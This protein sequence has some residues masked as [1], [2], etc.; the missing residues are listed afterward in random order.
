MATPAVRARHRILLVGTARSGTS[1]LG[2]AMGRAPGARFYYEPDN[3]DADPTEANSA[4]RRGFGPYPLI[5]PGED[6]NTFTPLWDMVFSGRFPFSAG[7]KQRLRPAARAVLQMPRAIRDPIVRRAATLSTRLPSRPGWTIVKSIYATFSL[8]WLTQRYQ[9]Q[10]VAIQRHPFNV[11]SSWRQLKIP[12]FDLAGRP[13]MRERFLHPLGI[14]P[15]AADASELT[16]IAWHVGLLTHVLGDAVD[17]HPD[18]H[19]ATHEDL[20]AD[21]SR[22]IHDIFDRVG[23]TWTSG[24]ERFL[25]E[26]DQPGEGLKPVRVTAEQPDR[27][28]QRLSPA[29]VAEIQDELAKFPRRGWVRQPA[30][31]ES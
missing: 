31:V 14:Q 30:A 4:G 15:P 2:Y 6:D 11:V 17:R 12:L 7:G 3:V 18:W 23:L 21:P 5:E 24:V 10:V 22:R 16:Q 8:D 29:E 1:W 28:R 9:P 19:L 26:N 25:T 20:C 13:A 27:W